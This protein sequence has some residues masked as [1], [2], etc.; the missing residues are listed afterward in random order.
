[1]NDERRD[2]L[3]QP[4]VVHLITNRGHL[5]S[6]P[7]EWTPGVM[8]VEHTFDLK[9][10]CIINGYAVTHPDGVV[11]YEE[12]SQMMPMTAGPFTVGANISDTCDDPTCKG[13]NPVT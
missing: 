10:N 4:A 3:S 5:S 9:H 2:I 11:F 1:M 13:C 7:I 8:R 12:H 6:P